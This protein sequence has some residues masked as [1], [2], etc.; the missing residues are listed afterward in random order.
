MSLFD[1]L[2]TDRIQAMKDKD[3]TR[4]GCLS[5]IIADTARY[6]KMPSDD[7]VIAIIK[8][9]IEICKDVISKVAFINDTAADSYRKQIEILTLYLPS[10]V[11]EDELKCFIST[12]TGNKGA[13][14]KA[15]K[16]KYGQSVD[17]AVASKI[18]S[19]IVKQ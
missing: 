13:M 2:K 5:V 17:M 8:K 10:M 15:I 12:L 1:K 6:N 14:M 3:D 4:A 9:D 19:E 7:E 16:L 18:V 11:S